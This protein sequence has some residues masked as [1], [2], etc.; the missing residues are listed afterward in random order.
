MGK[1]YQYGII[2]DEKIWIT[3]LE[4]RNMT[5]HVYREQDV[6]KIFEHIQNHYIT[7]LVKT[8]TSLDVKINQRN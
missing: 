6:Q 2:D 4:D 5:C 1:A 7:V 3:M 8:Y